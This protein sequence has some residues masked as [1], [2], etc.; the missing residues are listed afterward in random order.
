MDRERP[1][2]DGRAARPGRRRAAVGPPGPAARGAAARRGVLARLRR[3]RGVTA[4]PARGQVLAWG[5]WDWGS[6]AFNA[7]ILTFVFSVY[8]TGSVGDDLPGAVSA[9]SWLGYALGAAGLVVAVLAPVIGQRAD[10]AGRRKL[11]VGVWTALDRRQHGGH[12][13][14]PRRPAGTSRSGWSC[15][16]S[17]RSSSS[18][19]RCPT[20]RCWSGV[21]TPATIGR[22]SGFGWAM[23]YFGGIVLLLGVYVG[24]IAGGGGLLGRAHRGRVQHPA[25]GAG[26]RRLVRRVRAAA[27][28]AVPE[29]APEPRRGRRGS[30]WSAPTGSWSPTCAS[31]Y[32]RAPHTVYFLGA[33]ALFRDGA[34]RDLRLRRGARGHR[35]RHRRRRRADLRGRRQRDLGGRRAGR[36]ADRRPGRARRRSSSARWSG[37]LVAGGVLLVVSGPTLFWIFGLFLTLF[38]GPGAVV[39][40][41][42]PGAARPARARGPAVRAVRDDR[43]RG[44]VP[45]PHAGRAVHPAVRLG[46]G[47]DRRHP[48]RA[49]ARAGR[50]VAGAPAA[51]IGGRPVPES[52]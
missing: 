50:A 6:S 5:L 51:A 28:C 41:H 38:V 8:L 10:A 22:V 16:A 37:M 47:R 23:G 27:V 4:P 29:P 39:V 13:P 30:A 19:P 7:V 25:G 35:L 40:A 34:G 31:C 49:G 24:F 36:R 3:L 52:E 46:P 14:G 1:G 33:S 20:T 45:R 12:V 21:S 9:N 15:S 44:V 43:P 26:R 17:A 18:W 48:A 2:R 32:R 42:L 11:S